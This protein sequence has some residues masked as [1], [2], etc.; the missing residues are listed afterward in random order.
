MTATRMGS[1]HGKPAKRGAYKPTRVRVHRICVDPTDLVLGR[2]YSGPEHA[3][4]RCQKLT[5][6]GVIVI[7]AMSDGVS[8]RPPSDMTTITP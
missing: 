3:C 5:D 4:E 6:V 2:F 1:S 8:M 7:M